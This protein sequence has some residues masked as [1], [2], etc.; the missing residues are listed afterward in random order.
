[1]GTIFLVLHHQDQKGNY[2]VFSVFGSFWSCHWHCC[3]SNQKITW[4]LGYKRTEKKK[5]EK[6]WGTSSTVLEHRKILHI[7][8][9][10]EVFSYSFLAIS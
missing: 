2:P 9:E 4:D 3:C 5:K 7:F 6:Y 1:M 8:I 10:L